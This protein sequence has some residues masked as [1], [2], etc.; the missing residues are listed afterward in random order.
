MTL[1]PHSRFPT[2]CLKPL[3]HL[4]LVPRICSRPREANEEDNRVELSSVTPATGS[5][6]LRHHGAIF[7][8]RSLGPQ[9]FPDRVDSTAV[10]PDVSMSTTLG[11]PREPKMGVEPIAFAIPRRRTS[12]CASSARELSQR[13]ELCHRPYEGQ[14][15]TMLQKRGGRRRIRTFVGITPTR[16]SNPAHCLTLS[17]YRIE[18]HQP[19][20][21]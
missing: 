16:I 3:D 12:K 10:G 17:S 19:E 18:K 4:T 7:R 1:S 2:E 13:I 9:L 15:N 5:N 6:R 21:S 20:G 8:V 14:A 11:D